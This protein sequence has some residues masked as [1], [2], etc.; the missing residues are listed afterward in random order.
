MHLA[1]YECAFVTHLL[2]C[3]AIAVLKQDPPTVLLPLLLLPINY[4][5]Y[6]PATAALTHDS[7]TVL[8]A[9]AIILPITDLIYA[10][11]TAALTH[12]CEE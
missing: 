12:Y 9:I 8:V 1:I 11:A 7:S 6:G 2:L 10:P 4:L 3:T 5:I